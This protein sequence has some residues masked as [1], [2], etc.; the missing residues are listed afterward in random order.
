MLVRRV[1]QDAKDYGKS[2]GEDERGIF[3]IESTCYLSDESLLNELQIYSDANLTCVTMNSLFDFASTAVGCDLNSRELY[4]CTTPSPRRRAILNANAASAIYRMRPNSTS[5][6]TESPH[7]TLSGR[8]VLVAHVFGVS[9]KA[10]RDIWNLR[11]WRHVT[12]TLRFTAGDR[13]ATA[14][15]YLSVQLPAAARTTR[16]VGRPRGRPRGSKDSQPRR[17]TSP[18]RRTNAAQ[19]PTSS[20]LPPASLPSP[21]LTLPLSPPPPPS[22]A[23][24]SC[25]EVLSRPRPGTDNPW[26]SSIGEPPI[27]R[28][29]SPPALSCNPQS[30]W[31]PPA[32]EDPELRRCYPFFLSWP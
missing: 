9:P 17:R 12:E 32:E 21:P 3:P 16:P 14:S 20:S 23:S 26:A 10:V 31:A 11:T 13:E 7:D 15:H 27:G 29:R 6:R 24:V 30:T 8:S 5:L 25:A 4:R 22:L 28:P 19:G 2:S 1:V 18:V